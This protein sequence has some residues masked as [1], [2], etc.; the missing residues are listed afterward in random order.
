MKSGLTMAKRVTGKLLNKHYGLGAAQARY[1]E[2]GVWFHPLHQ[3]PG[4]LFDAKGYV[5]FPTQEDY[6]KSADVK[7]GPDPNHIHVLGGI[8]DIPGY[9]QLNPPPSQVAE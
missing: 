4:I 1:R 5:I 3:F 8:A 6:E 9:V 2:N 7:K